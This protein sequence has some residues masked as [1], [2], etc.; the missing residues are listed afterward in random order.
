MEKNTQTIE[1]T[2]ACRL[3]RSRRPGAL[4]DFLFTFG[5]KTSYNLSDVMAWLGL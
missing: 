4:E 1:Y 3:V 2:N 5:I